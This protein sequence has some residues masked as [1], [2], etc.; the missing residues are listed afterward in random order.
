LLDLKELNQPHAWLLNREDHLLRAKLNQ[1]WKTG[2]DAES[3][4]AILKY[5]FTAGSVSFAPDFS[6]M[7]HNDRQAAPQT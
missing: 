4:T 6:L 1:D 2:G 3:V 5:N 7:D